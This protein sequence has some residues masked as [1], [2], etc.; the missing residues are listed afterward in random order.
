MR[1]ILSSYLTKC[2][3]TVIGTAVRW[4]AGIGLLAYAGY[5][6]SRHGGLHPLLPAAIGTYLIIRGFIK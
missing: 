4:I 1:R 6:Y 3:V 5:A 2:E